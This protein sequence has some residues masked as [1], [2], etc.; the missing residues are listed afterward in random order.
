MKPFRLADKI[1]FKDSIKKYI[2][3]YFSEVRE[4][5]KILEE[6]KNDYGEMSDNV[7]NIHRESDVLI[8]LKELIEQKYRRKYCPSCFFEYFT[9]SEKMNYLM[10]RNDIDKLLGIKNTNYEI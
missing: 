2:E 9:Q 4:D 7:V 1:L 6:Y 10:L 5:I 3:K 8:E